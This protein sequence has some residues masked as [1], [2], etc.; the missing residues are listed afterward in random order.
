MN[1][2]VDES[3]PSFKLTFYVD[4]GLISFQI[5]CVDVCHVLGRRY[6]HE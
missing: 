2:E 3:G 4:K 1:Q 6:A 5:R